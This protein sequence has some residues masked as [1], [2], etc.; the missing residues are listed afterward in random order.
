M[1]ELALVNG[2]V[3]T[4]TGLA[5]G[6]AV[7]LAA[8]QIVFVG[9]ERDLPANLARQTL[10]GG[11]LLPGFIDTQVNG[12]G[13]VL[14]NDDPTAEGIA[15][16]GA[17]HRRFG[18]TSF[19]PTL[20]SDHLE[21]V[22]AGI[23]AT[24]QAMAERQPGVLGIH[25]EGPFLNPLRRGIHDAGR[26]I[27]FDESIF[28]AV[29]SLGSGKCL[30]TLAPEGVTP[31]TIRR[32]VEAGIIV[33]GGHT[34][35]TYEQTQEALKAGLSGFTH[36][37]NAMSPLT[38]RKPGVVGAA[39]EDQTAWCGLIV[40]GMHVA[41][42]TLRL[43]LKCRPLS[44]FM[45]VTDAMPCVGSD[46]TSFVLNGKE[47]TVQDGRCLSANGTLAGSSLDMATAL[48]NAVNLLGLSLA[49]ASRMASLYPAAFL[50][51]DAKLGR[52]APGYRAN[53]VLL[54]KALTVQ[55]TWIEGQDSTGTLA[56]PHRRLAIPG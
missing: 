47:I 16:I 49:E 6:L 51:L 13:G 23:A 20:I 42:A 5:D 41:P 10:D 37:F 2:R 17:A 8:G 3:M 11:L 1:M 35:A 44:R 12:G 21:V 30:V 9:P 31:D 56:S 18:T 28:S 4:D 22:R 39:L 24:V 52:I 7:G 26:I 33:A 32:L 36:L 46:Q 55:E 14:F 19:L 34:D 25:L 27:S 15:A 53:L 40:D 48:R 38:S 50:G 43:A 54:D 29:Q 45:L